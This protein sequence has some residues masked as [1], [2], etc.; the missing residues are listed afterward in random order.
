[1][2]K[3][4]VIKLKHDPRLEKDCWVA[5][6]EEG[7]FAKMLVA[8]DSIGEAVKEMG[9]SIQVMEMYKNQPA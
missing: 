6:I 9:I 8:A 7:E 1:M 2:I 4:I 5:Y 3:E